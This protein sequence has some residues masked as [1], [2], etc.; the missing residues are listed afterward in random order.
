MP[1]YVQD[2]LDLI[3]YANGDVTTEW[4]ARRAEAG[5]PEPFNL[6]YIGI[7]NEDLIGEVFVPRFKMIYDAV[8]E[9][10]PEVTVIGTVGPFFEGSDYEAGWELARELD[11]PMVDEHYYVAPGWYIYNRDFY[12]KYPRTGTKVYLGEYASH[13]PGRPST[14]ETA[15]SIALYLT[16]VERNA[17]V[18]TMTSYAPLLAKNG[19]TQWR[20]DLIYFDNTSVYPTVDYQ[21][22]K[23]YGNNSGNSYM[24]AA[25]NIAT[26]NDKAKARV[27]SSIVK[28]EATGDYIVKLV[29][30]LPVAANVNLDLVPLGVTAEK[31]MAEQ[32]AGD[33][34]AT[35]TAVKKVEISL[36][37]AVLPPYSFT[38]IRLSSKAR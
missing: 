18:V 1:D 16:D 29:N 17:D 23:L 34:A 6:K 31:V 35:D 2:V 22:Q 4:G 8:R 27:G 21:V 33:P 5:H 7:G 9:K 36:P 20:P 10:Y 38:V 28:D 11:I 26:D 30:M 19:H 15:L 3:E 13:A 25:V 14:L 24:P 37:E 12:D 32:L